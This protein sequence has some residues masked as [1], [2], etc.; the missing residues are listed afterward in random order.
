MFINMALQSGIPFFW[1][2]N[3][4]IL[5]PGIEDIVD[6]KFIQSA[7]RL[8]TGED[9]AN[10]T[11]P[12][13]LERLR[14][15][16]TSQLH[17]Q[18]PPH[19]PPGHWAGDQAG[20]VRER[21]RSSSSRSPHGPPL[22]P[23]PPQHEPP[24]YW[25]GFQAGLAAQQQQP[26]QQQQPQQHWHERSAGAGL[27]RMGGSEDWEALVIRRNHGNG[28]EIPKGHLHGAE[29][30]QEAAKRELMEETGL[31]TPVAIGAHLVRQEY[32]LANGTPK[33]VDYYVSWFHEDAGPEV[34]GHREAATTEVGWVSLAGLASTPFKHPSIKQVV[35]TALEVGP[36]LED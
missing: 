4:V 1:S 24:G 32:P 12:W 14:I 7:I 8:E 34:Y 33:I 10:V 36:Y 26:W 13:H 19:P 16:Q 21:S 35:Q 15:W 22:C 6:R 25:T 9:L 29:T 30:P 28:F 11:P 17:P 31:Q 5:S 18:P 27:I 23:Q 20:Q 2:I 3:G